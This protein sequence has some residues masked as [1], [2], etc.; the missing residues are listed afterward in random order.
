MG[1]DRA[2][3]GRGDPSARTDE[4]LL[5][6][7][8]GNA[9]AEAVILIPFFILVWGFIIWGSHAYE[10]TLDEGAIARGHAWQHVMS[11]CSGSVP[12]GTRVRDVTDPPF[13]PV[14]EALRLIDTLIDALPLFGDYWPGFF[15]DENEYH[16]HADIRTPQ[17]IGGDTRRMEYD[18]VL[19][20]N[21]D[22]ETPDFEAIAWELFTQFGG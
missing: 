22:E 13:G 20:C 15:P 10:R 11:S 14:G 17:V 1:S 7:T 8:R 2:K 18:I 3:R 9:T 4:S 16:R 19:M 12:A 5:R 21:E 6:D